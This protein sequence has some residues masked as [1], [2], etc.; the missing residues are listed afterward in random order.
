[1]GD[2]SNG[3]NPKALPIQGLFTLWWHV[4]LGRVAYLKHV[5]SKTLALPMPLNLW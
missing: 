3:T 2:K 4:S 5:L 1:M